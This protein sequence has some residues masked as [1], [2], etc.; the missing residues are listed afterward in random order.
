MRKDILG[1]SA[2]LQSP[3]SKRQQA[4]P[5]TFWM[6]LA[7]DL[8]KSQNVDK[9]GENECAA[10]DLHVNPFTLNRQKKD[11]DLMFQSLGYLTSNHVVPNGCIMQQLCTT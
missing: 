3:A 9:E 6:L 7:M 2:F 4:N 5:V 8:K 10:F 1:G 11:V